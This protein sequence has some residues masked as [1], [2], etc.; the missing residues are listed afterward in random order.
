MSKKG[1]LIGLA[2]GTGSGKTSVA[3][4][5]TQTFGTPEVVLIEQDAYYK[6]LSH[7]PFDQRVKN[8][9]DHPQSIDFELLYDH[10]QTLLEGGSVAAPVYNFKTH[11]RTEETQHLD[12]HHILVLEGIFALY[13]EKIRNLM[14]IKLFV[15]TEA[16]IRL[17]R[18][19][20]RD[21]NERGRTLDS[22]IEQYCMT[23]RP[24]HNQFVEP[25]KIHAD[26]IIPE[27][28]QNKV[29]IDLLQTKIRSLLSQI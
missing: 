6:D 4:A 9:F 3:R 8:N 29:A 2:G 27:G 11:T 20:T 26:I 19:L 7:L 5:I 10:I 12:S 13:D 17:L 15:D 1:I 24:M 25:T 22:V 21:M 28:G 23:V 16:D 14:D 18:R